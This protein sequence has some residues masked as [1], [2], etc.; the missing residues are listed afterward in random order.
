MPSDQRVRFHNREHAA[1]VD[2]PRQDNERYP[3]CIVGAARFHLALQAQRQLLSQKQ[4]LSG[5]LGMRSS[6]CGYEAHEVAGNPQDAPHRRATWGQAMAAGSHAKSGGRQGCSAHV[7][8]SSIG[9]ASANSAGDGRADFL[10][11]TGGAGHQGRFHG[12]R[13]DLGRGDNGPTR[14]DSGRGPQLRRRP[15]HRRAGGTATAM[16]MDTA[17]DTAAD[18]DRNTDTEG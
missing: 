2:Q 7:E 5:E 3:S 8:H 12:T 14:A 9:S 17:M 6:A 4:I 16:V 10:R 15:G 18:S 11:S 1:P 13:A